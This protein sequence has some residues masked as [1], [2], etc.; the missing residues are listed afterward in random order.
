M[1]ACLLISNRDDRSIQISE[2]LTF[3]SSK[4]ELA[5]SNVIYIDLDSIGDQIRVLDVDSIGNQIHGLIHDLKHREMQVRVG[6]APTRFASF[7]A[8]HAADLETP[9][10]ISPTQLEDLLG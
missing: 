10:F 8:A 7:V 5:D 3:Y 6:I 2:L 4:W 9:R 1:L